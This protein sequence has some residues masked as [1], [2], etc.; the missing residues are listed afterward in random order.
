MRL[1]RWARVRSTTSTRARASM[2]PRCGSRTRRSTNRSASRAVARSTA[3]DGLPA[4][5][6]SFAGAACPHART[7]QTL[8]PAGPGRQRSAGCDRRLDPDAGA[9]QLRRS[10]A[11][12][13]GA[14]MAEHAQLRST[15]ASRSTSA[16]WQRDSNE[17]TN[18]LLRQYFPRGTELSRHSPDELAD[19]TLPRLLEATT[20]LIVIRVLWTKVP[21][22]A[23]RAAVDTV[24]MDSVAVS[25]RV[26]QRPFPDSE[27]SAFS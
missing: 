22:P 17:S 2:I 23:A 12:D 6:T 9:Q 13:Q 16:P 15:P 20:E 11:W 14:E 26:A 24:N 8:R 3:A 1:C 18:S 4:H 7:R 19:V 25:E 27:L 10:P 21:Q 5:R